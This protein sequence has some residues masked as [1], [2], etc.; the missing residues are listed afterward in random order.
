MERSVSAV[1]FIAPIDA[2]PNWLPNGYE[3]VTDPDHVLCADDALLTILGC[4]W[5]LVGDVNFGRRVGLR[6]VCAGNDIR[7]LAKRIVE[8]PQL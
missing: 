7:Y 6:A 5:R 2:S 3:L 4:D 1:E 8:V